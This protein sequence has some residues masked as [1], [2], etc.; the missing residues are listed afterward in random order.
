MKKFRD[1][2]N[3][4]FVLLFGWCVIVGLVFQ[5]YGKKVERE[6][7]KAKTPYDESK[8]KNDPI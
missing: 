8:K 7:R 4:I 3:E 2:R 6:H 1:W 5:L